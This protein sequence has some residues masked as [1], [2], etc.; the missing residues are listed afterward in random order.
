MARVGATPPRGMRPDE[1][2]ALL[3]VLASD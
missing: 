1:V 3:G 2:A